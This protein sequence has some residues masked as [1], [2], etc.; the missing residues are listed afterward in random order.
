ME[1]LEGAMAFAVAMIIFSTMAT[2]IVE[3]FLRFAHTK[4]KLLAD[5]IHKMF[6]RALS[7]ETSD[8]HEFVK[9]K[10][11]DVEDL[12]KDLRDRLTENPAAKPLNAPDAKGGKYRVDVLTTAAFLKRFSQ[13]DIGKAVIQQAKDRAKASGV[14]DEAEEVKKALREWTDTFERYRATANERF[15]KNTHIATVLVAVAMALA[16]NIHA[17]RLFMG[18]MGSEGAELRNAL[19]ES[20]EDRHSA[21][22][23]AEHQLNAT[24]ARLESEPNIDG[25]LEQQIKDLRAVVDELSTDEAVALMPIGT[26]YYPHCHFSGATDVP[27]QCTT[28]L[29]SLSLLGWFVNAL[30]AGVLIGLGGPFWYRVFS[31]LSQ[32][33]QAL[34]A[35]GTRNGGNTETLGP[36][37]SSQ[38]DA[39]ASSEDQDDVDAF[40]KNS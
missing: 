29:A 11:F 39:S 30:L 7:D 22:V 18:V 13:T 19:I 6:S 8:I 12:A 1:I 27:E 5:A 33:T 9:S 40:V 35:F 16:F 24:L 31:S 32:L 28:P 14:K 37:K 3:V 34:K 2:G 20:A 15:R 26:D 25:E 36:G 21:Y 17:G 4:P 38:T 10:G 23:A